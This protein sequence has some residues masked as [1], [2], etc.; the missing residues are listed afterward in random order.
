MSHKLYTEFLLSIGNVSMI[1][2]HPLIVINI[3]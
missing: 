2:D 1:S 3:E